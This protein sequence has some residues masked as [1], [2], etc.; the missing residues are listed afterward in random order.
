MNYT[1]IQRLADPV[2]EIPTEPPSPL[3]KPSPLPLDSPTPGD[4]PLGETRM[5]IALDYGT[6]FTGMS[7]GME[8]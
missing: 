3:R 7:G 4:G 8:Y 1:P 2:P 6:T 5:V